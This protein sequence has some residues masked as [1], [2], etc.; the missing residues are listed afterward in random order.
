MKR[1]A[2]TAVLLAAVMAAMCLA[3][4][5][6]NGSSSARS[7]S[8]AGASSEAGADTQTLPEGIGEET[9]EQI[10]RLLEQAHSETFTGE[11]LE[12]K[13]ETL[14]QS[15]DECIDSLRK[16]ADLAAEN[17]ETEKQRNIEAQMDALTEAKENLN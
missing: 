2:F 17:H 9:E 8:P 4:C 7:E 6:G 1:Y 15:I 11:E 5:A 14:R 13:K 3:A 12:S 10:Q 16:D